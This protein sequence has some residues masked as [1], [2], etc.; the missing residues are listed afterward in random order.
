M[1]VKKGEKPNE[2]IMKEKKRNSKLYFGVILLAFVFG[3]VGG[4]VGSQVVVPY[5]LKKIGK[6]EKVEVTKTENVKVEEN[7][8]I[9]DAVGKVKGS[10]VSITATK[11]VF[12][13]FQGVQEQKSGGTGFI[14]TQ[15]GYIITNKHVVADSKAKYSVVTGDGKNYDAK[16]TALDPF[17]DLAVI[18]IE[19]TGLAVVEIGDA[20]KIEVG[21]RVIAIGNALGLSEETLTVT[22]GIISAKGRA[23]TASDV[24]G[25]GVEKLENLFQTDAA[26]NPGNSGGPLLNIKGQVIGINVAK[27]QAENVGFA[28]TIETIKPIDAFIKNLRE[29]GKIVRPMIGIRYISL[30][31]AIAQLNNLSVSKGA[32]LKSDPRTGLSAVVS[33]GPADEAGIEDGDIITEVGGTEIS[34]TQSLS[35]LIQR[36]G[37]GDSVELTILRDGKEKKVKVV[38]GEFKG[39]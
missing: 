33:G 38:L 22:A 4:G 32:W 15:D 11:N 29:K 27:A 5:F 6:T 39:S 2:F 25:A 28:I 26:I 1:E 3:V 36:F 18:K 30:T 13:I 10:V 8:A 35:V 14:L 7:S 31:K 9:V 34:E 19:A 24:S 21:S 23:I 20:S 16:V 37:P 12:D 17:N